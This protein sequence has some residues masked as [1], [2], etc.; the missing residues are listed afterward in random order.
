M[1]VFWVVALCSLVEVVLMME[2]ARTSET[3]VNFYQT[4]RCYNPEDSHLGACTVYCCVPQEKKSCL[5]HLTTVSQLR[6]L[7]IISWH[8][9]KNVEQ[10][11]CAHLLE[12]QGK[13]PQISLT[14]ACLLWFKTR[15]SQIWCWSHNDCTS[16]L[17]LMMESLS[18]HMSLA[19]MFIYCKYIKM[20]IFF[21]VFVYKYAILKNVSN[22]IV[23]PNLF[24]P[25]VVT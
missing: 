20:Y 25:C 6:R 18:L 3:L 13:L 24:W 17:D 8:D 11:I 5:F 7:C 21:L 19:S 15:A 2:A 23:H 10:S 12:G 16:L 22:N 4:T 9:C 1:A 14:V